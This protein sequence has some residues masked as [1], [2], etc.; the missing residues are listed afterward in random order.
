MQQ[1][2][3]VLQQNATA[4]YDFA[5]GCHLSTASLLGAGASRPKVG[6]KE[7]LDGWAKETKPAAKTI[8]T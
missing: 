5:S 4:S 6:F 7:L 8:Y 3:R 2:T 1:A